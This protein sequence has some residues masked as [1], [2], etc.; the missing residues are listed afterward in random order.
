MSRAGVGALVILLIAMGAVACDAPADRPGPDAAEPGDT[1]AAE[2]TIPG[3]G[4]EGYDTVFVYFDGPVQESGIEGPRVALARAVPP[5]TGALTHALRELLSGPT[6]EDRTDGPYGEYSSWFS[7]ET[8]GMLRSATLEDGLAVVDFHD[9]RP[10]I[11][12]ASTS[13]GSALLLGQLEATVFQFP[14]V[15]RVEL[16]IDGDC[17]AFMAWLQYGCEQLPRSRFT[18]PEG[19]R[20]AVPE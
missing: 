12:N 19:H 20:M 14:E 15:R 17:E 11:P 13:A 16:R 7:T 2:S 9:L 18:A 6:P 1:A 10:V 5:G 4:L 3:S 8:A